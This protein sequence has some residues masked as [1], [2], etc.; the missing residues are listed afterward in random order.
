M[1]YHSCCYASASGNFL[2][3][4]NGQTLEDG[5]YSDC[6][7]EDVG[8]QTVHLFVHHGGLWVVCHGFPS[9]HCETGLFRDFDLGWN[10]FDTCVETAYLNAY[11]SSMVLLT[12]D[13]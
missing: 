5:V 9:S 6:N 8:G 2:L 7:L 12:L 13:S 4:S 3:N 10:P 1:A 11:S